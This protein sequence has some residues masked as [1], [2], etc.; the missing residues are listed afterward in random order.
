MY[1]RI[2]GWSLPVHTQIKWCRSNAF[3]FIVFMG[4]FIIRVYFVLA[5]ARASRPSAIL[6][7]SRIDLVFESVSTNPDQE[8]LLNKCLFRSAAYRYRCMSVRQ[9]SH[10][11]TPVYF[12]LLR[13]GYC[14][15]QQGGGIWRGGGVCQSA[16]LSH[17]IS[18]LFLFAAPW[19][20]LRAARRWDMGRRQCL[21]VHPTSHTLNFT[22]YIFYL[23]RHGYCWEQQGG[24][25][26]GGGSA[27]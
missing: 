19:L 26:W 2:P 10:T 23:Q 7:Y 22:A 8:Y 5:R 20:L 11:H 14:W 4:I 3:V 27:C 24:G 12:Y 18:Y 9:T 21:L 15:E 17:S 1:P 6:N 25:I 16:H 13:H